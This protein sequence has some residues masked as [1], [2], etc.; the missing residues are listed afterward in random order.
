MSTNNP[1]QTIQ[2]SFHTALG[3]VSEFTALLQEPQQFTNYLTKIQQ[4][5]DQLFQDLALKGKNMEQDITSFFKNYFSGDVNK[6]P[7]PKYIERADGQAF[8]QPYEIKDT[9]MYG[10]VVEGSMAKL[11]EVC[12]KYLNDPNNGEI[13][14]RPATNY[15]ILTFNKID[16]LSSIDPPDYEKGTVHEEE[17]IFWMLTVVGR[18]VGPLFI[19]E[20]LACFM[21]YLYVNNSPILVSGREVYGFFKQLGKFQIPDLNQEP[22]LLTVDTLVFK[23]FSP[24]SQ[25]LDTRLLEV[26]RISTGAKH[27]AIKT[28][29]TFEEA[30]RAIASLLF[31]NEEIAVPGLQLP[32]NLLEYLLEKVVPL[33]TLK[34]IRDVENSKKACYQALVESPMQ[35]QTFYGGKLFGFN[36]FGDQFQLKI[37]KF[38]SQP[39]VQDLGLDK[40]YP[41]GSESVNIAVKLGFVL[42]FDFILKDGKI[43]WEAPQKK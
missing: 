33:V 3:A 24:T 40:G 13:E 6:L 2:T 37:N 36:G 14:Y 31:N 9:K 28:W 19:A 30:V 5:P 21:P 34:Q 23:E 25:A 29:D 16:S 7:Y 12:D 26:Q 41:A 42:H 38:A 11:Q 32:F 4:K 15:L 27:Q 43:V 22:D 8:N 17:A 10:F 35:L 20:R 39:I 18:R 1:L